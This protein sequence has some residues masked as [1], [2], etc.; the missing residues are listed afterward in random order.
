MANIPLQ[1][2]SFPGLSD[3]Y[4]T[5]TVDT[6]LT[7]TGAAA[8]AKK[9]GDEI[10]GLK[11]DFIQVQEKVGEDINIATRTADTIIGTDGSVKYPSDTITFREADIPEGV[12]SVTFTF[13]ALGE[14]ST[15]WFNQIDANGNVLSYEPFYTTNSPVIVKNLLSGTKKIK[16]SVWADNNGS[17]V[18]Y[19]KEPIFVLAGSSDLYASFVTEA[20]T[21]NIASFS[22]GA[23]GVPVKDLTVA[24]EPVQSGSGDPSPT[25]IRPIS[26]WTG[27][28]VYYGGKNMLVLFEDGKVPSVSNGALVD[29]PGARSDYIPIKP[30]TSYALSVVADSV[31]TDY[32]FYYDENK[33]FIRYAN[34]TGVIIEV[35]PNNAKYV[36]IRVSIDAISAVTQAQFEEGNV[37]TD[38][39]PTSTLPVNWTTEAGTVY[40]GTLDVTTGVL[41]VDRAIVDLGTITNWGYDHA[42][43]KAFDTNVLATLA[44]NNDCICSAYKTL[45]EP[46]GNNIASGDMFVA[47]NKKNDGTSYTG[48]FSAGV[49]IVKDTNYTDVNS[50]VS[51]MSGVQFAYKLAT[52]QTYQLT[53][54]EVATVLGQNNIFADT[55]NVTVQYRADTKLYIGKVISA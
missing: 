41:T 34:G 2:I 16:Y 4:T 3:K 32:I 10:S 13:N 9:T 55:G 51:A 11:N 12:T 40:G 18:T 21:G 1:S 22:D 15:H 43:A 48:N 39:N 24:I 44:K 7:Q 53:P 17:A 28:K 36:M 35:S 46:F 29:A 31:L 8:D 5:P 42:S 33:N 47:I 23:D 30:S 14:T 20:A 26:G 52:P 49:L 54:Q 38:Y 19:H 27:A 45:S 25:N 37:V 50:F 6:T